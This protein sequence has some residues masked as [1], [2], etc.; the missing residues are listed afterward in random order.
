M[1]LALQLLVFVAAI[2]GMVGYGFYRDKKSIRGPSL[3]KQTTGRVPYTFPNAT[4]T[5]SDTVALPCLALSELPFFLT[6]SNTG[7]HEAP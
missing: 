7:T 3:G 1:T 5:M 4:R 6:T 2:A